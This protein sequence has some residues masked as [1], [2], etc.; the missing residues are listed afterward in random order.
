MAYEQPVA[1]AGLAELAGLAGLVRLTA[2]WQALAVAKPPLAWQLNL[3]KAHAL[4]QPCVGAAIV[5]FIRGN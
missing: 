2:I 5:N 1:T 3:L 4:S